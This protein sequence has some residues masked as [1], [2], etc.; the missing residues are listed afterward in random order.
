MLT[1]F[2]PAHIMAEATQP[3]AAAQREFFSYSGPT[4]GVNYPFKVQYCG[5]I[6]PFSYNTL[7]N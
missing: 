5:G 2:R 6:Y 3:L 7:Y 1:I 4:A